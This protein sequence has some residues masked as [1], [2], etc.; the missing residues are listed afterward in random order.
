[1]EKQKP[2]KSNEKINLQ[3]LVFFSFISFIFVL[4]SSCKYF[5]FIDFFIYY[6]L[7]KYLCTWDKSR[8][9][10]FIYKYIIINV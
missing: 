9:S 1:M 5:N 10:F 7:I 4:L 2:T 8:A 3:V 6:N